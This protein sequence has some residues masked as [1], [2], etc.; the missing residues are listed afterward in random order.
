MEFIESLA[1]V[2][3]WTENL[4]RLSNFYQDSLNM[5][6]HSVRPG[7]VAFQFGD[8]RLSLGKHNNVVGQSEEP[9]RIMVNLGVSDIHEAFRTLESRGVSF[10]RSPEKEHWGGW[11][12][13]FFDPDGNL[14][15]LLEAPV[16]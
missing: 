10:I 15:Q 8:T 2:I 7:F 6:P 5:K 1:G 12:A 13:T 9:Y 3:I 16:G 14:L 11:V 4:D